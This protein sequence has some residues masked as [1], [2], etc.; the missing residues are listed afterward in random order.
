MKTKPFLFMAACLMLFTCISISYAQDT[1]KTCNHTPMEIKEI[2]ATKALIIRMDVPM[3]AIGDKM[4][5]CYGKLF[6]Y[7]GANNI[8]PAGPVFAVYYS[9][10]PEGNVIFEA[11]VPVAEASAGAGDVTYKEYPVM[12]AVTT[13][14][15]GAYEA[16]EPVYNQLMK[17]MEENKLE[18]N[19]SSWEVYLTDPSMVKNPED[20]KTLI[21]F[22]LK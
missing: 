2:D 9:W 5:E 1:V 11:G 20:N 15:S 13:L 8:A 3:S 18:S 4:G 6:Q 22:P 19:G 21:Y 12:K 7:I 10:E 14:Y 17:Y 16:M